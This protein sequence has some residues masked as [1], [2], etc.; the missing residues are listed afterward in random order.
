MHLY[1]TS[2]VL[3]K[4][5]CSSRHL[6]LRFIADNDLEVLQVAVVL[7]FGLRIPCSRGSFLYG[8]DISIIGILTFSLMGQINRAIVP[9][10][11]R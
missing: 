6:H 7:C 11:L 5:H 8:I 4:L 2:S 10:V 9:P 3:V 1:V